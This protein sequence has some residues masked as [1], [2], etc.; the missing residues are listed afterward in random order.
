MAST[1]SEDG[2]ALGR[3]Q[4]GR[5]YAQCQE[6]GRWQQVHATAVQA[7]LYFEYWQAVFTCCQRLQTAWITVEKVD[8]DVH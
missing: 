7:D 6:C 3:L 4:E 2:P 5:F 8:D 1:R